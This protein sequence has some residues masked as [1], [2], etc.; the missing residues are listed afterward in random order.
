MIGMRKHWAE[1]EQ[2]EQRPG[3]GN[4]DSLQGTITKLQ[5]LIS[6]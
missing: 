1:G 6:K 4:S 2:C 5:W 3:A